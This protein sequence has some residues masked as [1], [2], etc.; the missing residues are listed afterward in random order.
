[1]TSVSSRVSLPCEF[2]AFS[3]SVNVPATSGVP[4]IN[5][6]ELLR[7]KPFG[8]LLPATVHDGVSPVA[9]RAKEYAF[10]REPFGR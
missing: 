1:M 5:P 3:L 8:R 4:L 10:P 2:A 6:E 9:S 7:D